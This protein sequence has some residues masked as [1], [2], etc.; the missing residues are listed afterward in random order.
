MF[1]SIA[2]PAVSVECV[3]IAAS[4]NTEIW[5]LDPRIN[6]LIIKTSVVKMNEDM[7]K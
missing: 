3:F 2:W 6:S 5:Q 1:C 4:E 7:Q